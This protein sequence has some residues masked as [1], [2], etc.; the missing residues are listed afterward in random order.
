MSC[1]PLLPHCH[2]LLSHA[3]L[4]THGCLLRCVCGGVLWF[5]RPVCCCAACSSIAVEGLSSCVAYV[6][7]TT[8]PSLSAGT[9]RSLVTASVVNERLQ[10]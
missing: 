9:M 3:A 5:M 6:A 2:A 4:E 7:P 8:Y 10:D 1:L